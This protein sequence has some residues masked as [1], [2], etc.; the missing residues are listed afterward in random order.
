MSKARM[1]RCPHCHDVVEVV[2]IGYGVDWVMCDHCQR[3]VRW[4]EVE[5][6]Y[7]LRED[8]LDPAG[9]EKETAY[10]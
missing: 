9:A 4:T 6:K 10:H 2:W 8:G 3:R 7:L 5:T 1:M